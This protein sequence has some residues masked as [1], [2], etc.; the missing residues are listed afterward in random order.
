MWDDAY[1]GAVQSVRVV[2]DSRALPGL[3]NKAFN[4]AK[5][6]KALEEQQAALDDNVDGDDGDAGD[7]ARGGGG[8]EMG[9]KE[10]RASDLRANLEV[11]LADA[12]AEHEK[13]AAAAAQQGQNCPVLVAPPAPQQAT[14][15]CCLTPAQVTTGFVASVTWH[16]WSSR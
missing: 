1:P 15:G 13:A 10:A 3:L 11:R 14:T 12:L 4:L 8:G 7:G 2:R 6:V 16:V 9:T 5:E